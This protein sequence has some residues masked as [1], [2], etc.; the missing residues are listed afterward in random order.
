MA[1][2][3]SIDPGLRI[4]SHQRQAVGPWKWLAAL[5]V[6]FY[7]FTFVFE[8][9]V[10]YSLD[11]AGL[12][13]FVYLRDA[14]PPLIVAGCIYAWMAGFVRPM[15]LLIVLLILL[16]HFFIGYYYLGGLFQRMF[17][18]KVFLPLLLGIAYCVVT[19]G[20]LKASYIPWILCVLLVSVAAVVVN[21]FVAMPW[22][23]AQFETVF[24]VVEQARNNTALG[25]RR[26][27]GLAR[28]AYDAASVILV[29]LV[30]VLAY[31]RK[32]AVKFVLW[33]LAVVAIAL[34]TTKA[35]LL[36]AVILGICALFYET[37]HASRVSHVVM[38]GAL[39]LCV[40]MPVLSLYLDVSTRAVSESYAWWLSSFAD[41]M[42]NMWPRAFDVWTE[43]G[44][45]LVGRG[46][47]GLGFPQRYGS[48]EWK[49]FNVADN[50][51]VYWT[52]IFGMLG[53]IYAAL[54][55]WRLFSWTPPDSFNMKLVY[56]FVVVLFSFGLTANIVEQPIL[57]FSA[58][59]C[60]ALVWN[61]TKDN[62]KC[63][64]SERW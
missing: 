7:L 52:V 4:K 63:V 47:G 50:L 25:V 38:V 20:R 42:E 10:R 22:E 26:L 23:G 56:G 5:L 15:F 44:S 21:K 17:G 49:L 62:D 39:L 3:I 9:L 46:L 36:A 12:G 64:E 16:I 19:D 61:R 51:F 13:S 58:G 6:F 60:F 35:A 31:Y 59:F 33:L 14:V 57:L 29:C 28:A 27:T 53:W 54:L 37:R 32:P 18:F 1:I 55:L 8:G 11:L 34:T 43:N 40:G 2:A 30:I 41:R 45:V 48:G 24:G